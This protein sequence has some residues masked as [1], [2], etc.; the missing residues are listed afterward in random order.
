MAHEQIRPT[1]HLRL[2]NQNNR[3]GEISLTDIAKVAE[4]TQ[5]LVA[6]IA[7][8][9]IDDH[10]RGRPRRNIVRATTLTLVGLRSGSTILDIALPEPAS[11]I[12]STEDM[13]RELGEMALTVM[14]ESL[15]ILA[16]DDPAPVL[17]VGVDDRVSDEIDDW[18]RALRGYTHV[19]IDAELNDSIIRADLNPTKARTRLRRAVSQPSVPYVSANNQALTGRLYALNLRTGTFRI[20]DDARHSIQLSVPED[21]RNEAA[22]LVNTR[23]R[24]YG[25]ASVDKRHRLILFNVAALEQL[26]DLLDQTAFFERHELVPPPRPLEEHDL[27][28]GII[29]DLSD[30]EIAAFMAALEAD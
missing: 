30:D 17:P 4:H 8:G 26:P 3:D 6:R 9:M 11:D 24:A 10:A 14:A 12:L 19:S 16:E 18:L 29:Q 15:A 13:P 22:Q 27:Q 21:V 25:T 28:R 23:V 2:R 7:T 5:R 20:E 1:L